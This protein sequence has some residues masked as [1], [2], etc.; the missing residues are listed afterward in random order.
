MNKKIS[1]IVNCYNGEKFLKRAI[2][3][4]FLQTYENWEIIFWDN[5]STDSS[6][7][8]MR[9]YNDERIKIYQAK[10]KTLLYEARNLAL[11]KCEGEYVCFLDCDDWYSPNKLQSQINLCN[12]ENTKICYSNY[13][14]VN[15]SKKINRVLYTKELPSGY[16]H[17][18]IVNN[19]CIGIL[20]VMIEK[21][22]LRSYLFNPDYHIIG[23]F[24]LLIRLSKDKK[25]SSVQTPLAYYTWH[26]E[27][28]SSKKTLLRIQELERWY[29]LSIT[30]KLCSHSFYEEILYSKV[31][32]YCSKK[33]K[34]RAINYFNQMKNSRRKIRAFI[35]IVFPSAIINYFRLQSN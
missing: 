4:V 13:W 5:C 32:Y 8:I 30:N 22:L 21:E 28:E 12:N 31:I 6:V 10:D 11:E 35:A 24:D 15:S 2:D 25:I 17:S 29:K 27:N 3:S 19:Y 9:S 1:V 18:K 7:M 23:D 33:R 26:G 14:F 16:I 20:T 34:L